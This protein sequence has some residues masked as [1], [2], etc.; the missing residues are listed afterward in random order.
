[1]NYT[2][3]FEEFSGAIGPTDLALYAGVGIVLFVLFKDKLSPVQKMLLD[4]FSN[5][6]ETVSDIAD[7]KTT[8]PAAKE[9]VTISVPVPI[10]PKPEE[11]VFFQLV[12]AWKQ[13]RDLA[14][15]SKCSEAIAV[16]DNVFQYLSP[17]GC[18]EKTGASIDEQ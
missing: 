12:A 14:V 9:V 18:K 1:M 16:L 2:Q 13:T 4:L 17:N 6:K 3:S 11:D 10:P 5:V 8:T 7:N 15:K